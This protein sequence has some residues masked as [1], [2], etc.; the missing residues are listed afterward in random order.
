MP[1]DQDSADCYLTGTYSFF[2]NIGLVI[3]VKIYRL[4]IADKDLKLD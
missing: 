4:A 1:Q 2:L 3:I